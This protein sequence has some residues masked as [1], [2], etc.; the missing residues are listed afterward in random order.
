M[1]SSRI[2]EKL[3][4]WLSLHY[5]FP[6]TDETMSLSSGIVGGTA[7][8]YYNSQEEGLKGINRIVGNDF[9]N[10][11]FK[12]KDKIVTIAS[13]G[14]SM[15]AGSAKVVVADPLTLFERI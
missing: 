2:E 8:N 3:L 9:H 11:K 10:V 5:P 4:E 14:G 6:K 12:R 13:V 7:G 15:K 1:R